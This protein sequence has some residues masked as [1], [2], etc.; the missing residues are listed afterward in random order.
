LLAAL[1]PQIVKALRLKMNEL[2][3]AKR[4]AQKSL[5]KHPVGPRAFGADEIVNPLGGL[6]LIEYAAA[7]QL[8]L[9]FLKDLRL[10]EITHFNKPAVRVPYLK[11]D[12]T[13]RPVQIRTAFEGTHR[14]QWAKGSKPIPYGLWRL[15][16][17]KEVGQV[18]LVDGPSDC[19]GPRVHGGLIED[20]EGSRRNPR[21]GRHAEKVFEKTGI[22]ESRLSWLIAERRLRAVR[23]ADVTKT[24]LFW[25]DLVRLVAAV[26]DTCSVREG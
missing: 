8:P 5:F 2:F 4:K 22:P 25:A 19:P 20:T 3:P 6:T 21:P 17:S 26:L 1:A 7:K 13:V 10:T 24:R 9:S 11:E 12:G 23:I 14:F 16:E 18:T 15:G